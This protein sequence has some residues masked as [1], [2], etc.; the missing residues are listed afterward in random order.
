MVRLL[1]VTTGDGEF[2]VTLRLDWSESLRLANWIDAEKDDAARLAKS[3]QLARSL[4]RAGYSDE[5][6]ADIQWRL[7]AMGKSAEEAAAAIR[8]HVDAAAG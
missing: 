4:R 5:N 3:T 8:E 1:G 6:V 7:R 2:V